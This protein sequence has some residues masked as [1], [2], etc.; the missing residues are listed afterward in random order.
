MKRTANRAPG[1]VADP[2]G[3]AERR[4][5]HQARAAFDYAYPMLAPFLQPETGWQGRSLYHLG[6]GLMSENFPQLADEEIE[7]LLAAV[8]RVFAERSGAPGPAVA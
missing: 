5:Y 3:T 4:R 2:T 1:R 8:Q 6:F 7:A